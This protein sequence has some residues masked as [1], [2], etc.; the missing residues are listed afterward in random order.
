MRKL[1]ILDEKGENWSLGE[2]GDWGVKDCCGEGS[3]IA[4]G[5]D[6]GGVHP[7]GL[8]DK[9]WYTLVNTSAPGNWIWNR[10]CQYIWNVHSYS[11]LPYKGYGK[12]L[13]WVITGVWS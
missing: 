3:D 7:I 8:I 12:L 4:P 9:P 11:E 1:T 6:N 10:N 13:G 5:I 2:H